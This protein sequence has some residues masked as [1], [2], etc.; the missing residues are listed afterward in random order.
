MVKNLPEMQEMWVGSSGQEDSPEEG[1]MASIIIMIVKVIAFH[2][3]MTFKNLFYVLSH[4]F[5]Q[6]TWHISS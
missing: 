4:V 5:I 1:N 6:T 2:L 3:I